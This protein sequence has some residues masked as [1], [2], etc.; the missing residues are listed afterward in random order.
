MRCDNISK[1]LTGCSQNVDNS[2]APHTFFSH[3]V[4]KGSSMQTMVA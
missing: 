1:H 2:H 4:V 3:G